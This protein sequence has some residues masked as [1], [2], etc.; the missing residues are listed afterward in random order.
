M[1]ENFEEEITIK[2]R[3]LL[4]ETTIRKLTSKYLEF[5]NKI[6][7]LTRSEMSSMIKDILNEIDLIEIG[8]LK[9]QNYENLKD[10][11]NNYFQSLSSEI[12]KLY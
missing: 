5:I 1:N 6:N 3:I 10:I 7:S 4:R 8:I 9:A 11:D 12:G 2:N